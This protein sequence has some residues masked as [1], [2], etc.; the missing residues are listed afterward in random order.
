M[1]KLGHLNNFVKVCENNTKT[2]KPTLANP[3]GG[4]NGKAMGSLHFK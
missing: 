4:G 3:E 2:V 1:R